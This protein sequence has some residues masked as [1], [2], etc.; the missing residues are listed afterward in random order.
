MCTDFELP[1]LEKDG[2]NFLR[3]CR[4]DDQNGLVLPLLDYTV[5]ETAFKV[6]TRGKFYLKFSFFVFVIELQQSSALKTFCI[7]RV[8]YMTGTRKRSCGE[9]LCLFNEKFRAPS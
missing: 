1:G 9:L 2:D 7:F 8:C 4:S 3:S 6:F 5:H